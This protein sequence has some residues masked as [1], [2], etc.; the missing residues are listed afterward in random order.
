M[1]TLKTY[2]NFTKKTEV[3][4]MGELPALTAAILMELSQAHT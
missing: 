1:G 4:Q 2:Q 3:S